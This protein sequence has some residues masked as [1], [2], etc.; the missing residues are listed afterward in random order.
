MVLTEEMK[1]YFLDSGD[2]TRPII[3]GRHLVLA[4]G[5][6]L[7]SLI[8]MRMYDLGGNAFDA[9][10]AMC[11]AQSLLEFHNYGFG[12]EVPILLY[13]AKEGEVVAVNGNTVAPEKATIEA[14]KKLGLE[15]LIPNDHIL[16]AGVP[17]VPSALINVLDRYGSLSLEEILS[18]AIELATEGFVIDKGFAHKLKQVANRFK[19]D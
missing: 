8:G 3:R 15:H 2:T 16:S 11:F 9:G 5:H 14:Y 4:S 10:V 19:K 18:P 6:H 1:S 12:G 17:A 7:A 13:S